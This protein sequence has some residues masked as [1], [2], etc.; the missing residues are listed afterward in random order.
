V[1]KNPFMLREPQHERESPIDN[2][3]TQPFV[4]SV[5]KGDRR[6]F[7]TT[8]EHAEIFYCKLSF[9]ASSASPR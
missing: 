5:S 3:S 6:F 9:F 2:S 1:R 4:L 8:A 7:L